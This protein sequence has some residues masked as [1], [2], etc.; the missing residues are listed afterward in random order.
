ML[1]KIIEKGFFKGLQQK[2]G[3]EKAKEAHKLFFTVL[4]EN[5]SW[6]TDKPTEFNLIFT[7][8]VLADVQSIEKV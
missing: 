3:K 7:S 6:A 4:E 1:K 8:M 2:V 5:K